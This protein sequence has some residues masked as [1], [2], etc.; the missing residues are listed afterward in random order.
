MLPTSRLCLAC[1]HSNISLYFETAAVSKKRQ[2]VVYRPTFWAILGATDAVT[3]NWAMLAAPSNRIPIPWD[4]LALPQSLANNDMPVI[5]SCWPSCVPQSVT[6]LASRASIVDY[7][8]LGGLG[9]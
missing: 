5:V 3:S 7:A 8:G 2:A 6:M 1:P 4:S 9:R